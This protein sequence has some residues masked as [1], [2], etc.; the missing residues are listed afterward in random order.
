VRIYHEY[1]RAIL[2]LDAHL[3][4]AVTGWML[5]NSAHVEPMLLG[6]RAIGPLPDAGIGAYAGR[7]AGKEALHPRNPGLLFIGVP[8]HC[9]RR[10][11]QVIGRVT[12]ECPKT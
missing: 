9:G 1:Q 6:S 5:S 4:A 12:A 2:G 10:A 8:R 7:V 3:C 11:V